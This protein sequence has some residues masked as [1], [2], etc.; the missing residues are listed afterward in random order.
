[1]KLAPVLPLQA[2]PRPKPSVW[3][4]LLA[5]V[6]GSGDSTEPVT[7]D[8]PTVAWAASRV[9]KAHPGPA[10]VLPDRRINRHEPHVLNLHAVAASTAPVRALAVAHERANAVGTVELSCC[11]E[12]LQIRF[13]RISAFT[14]GYVPYPMTV[15][16]LVTIPYQRVT[17]VEVD[18]DELVHL[19]LDPSSTPYNKLALAGLVRD[20]S[21]DHVASHRQRRRLER[22]VSVAA[23]LVWMPVALGL[24]VAFRSVSSALLL[25]ISLTLAGTLHL[26][27]GSIA[28]R[29]VLFSRTT[30]QVREELLGELSWRLPP[31]RVR[32]EALAPRVAPQA[33]VA[34]SEQPAEAGTLR[35][36]LTTASVVAAAAVLVIIVG[37]QLLITPFP[38]TSLGI[39]SLVAP[40]EPIAPVHSVPATSPIEPDQP[41]PKRM[42]PAC[43]CDRADSALWND[44]LPRLSVLARNRGGRSTYDRPSVYPEIAVVN[45]TSQDLKDIVMVVDFIVGPREGRPARVVGKQDLFWE[46][47]LAPGLAVKWRTKGR[48]DDFSVTSF[49]PGLLT[50]QGVE[51]AP[52]DAFYKLSMTANTPSVRLHGAM[53][54]AYLGD[55]RVSEALE[56]LRNE[57]REEMAE[58]LDL[59]AQATRPVRVCQVR[60]SAA[61]QQQSALQ[62]EACVFNASQQDKLDPIIAVTTT[63]EGETRQSR[64]NLG[65]VLPA[66][67]GVVTSGVADVASGE[68]DEQGV[69]VNV[70]VES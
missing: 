3:K 37:R 19:W 26:V 15:G 32:R 64:W 36:M 65:A 42:L 51:P 5:R 56:K 28:S 47:K 6:W 68:S 4:R 9:A 60:A 13:V 25:A 24:N 14:D 67:A 63:R 70:V 30:A 20:E 58:T 38:Q 41:P 49:V 18:D 29:L 55:A 45:N 10:G 12:G 27:R 39:E 52:A 33:P 11:A 21:F 69:E 34:A 23:L 43:R 50:D 31:G 44:G 2:K 62:V 35:G 8:A 46:G 16:Q 7:L 61:P 17:R 1:M 66:G 22:N 48:G 59:L 57:G 54:L 40:S 53:M